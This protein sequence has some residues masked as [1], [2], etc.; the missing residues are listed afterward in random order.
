MPH[1]LTTDSLFLLL[2]VATLLFG[3][4]FF[5]RYT[6]T[7]TLHRRA[8]NTAMPLL[9]TALGSALPELALSLQ[10]TA[11]DY[12]TLALGGI[13]GSNAVNILLILGLAATLKPI[14]A[15]NWRT[16]RI[17]LYAL[18]AAI[19]LVVLL[20]SDWQNGFGPAEHISR[21]EGLILLAATI[22]YAAMQFLLPMPK[23]NASEQTSTVSSPAQT[24]HKRSSITLSFLLIPLGAALIYAGSWI[25]I[26]AIVPLMNA[27]AISQG[28][29]GLLIVA[30]IV[31]LPEAVA[32]IHLYRN[33]MNLNDSLPNIIGSSTLNVLLV[34]G[35]AATIHRIPMYPGIRFDWLI[36]CAGI[37]LLLAELYIGKG[38]RISRGEGVVL[39]IAYAAFVTYILFREANTIPRILL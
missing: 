5:T 11:N 18:L 21:T 27:A 29:M 10:A 20:G 2:G 24:T 28:T 6:L 3:A 26:R 33:R 16:D 19:I 37:I 35:L 25:S 1:S 31:A 12:P 13:V 4:A 34:I 8:I 38:R 17:N 15:P 36:V 7:L 23:N 14:D 22:L 30:C 32:V 9:I 39:I